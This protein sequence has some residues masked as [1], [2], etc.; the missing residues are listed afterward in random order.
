MGHANFQKILSFIAN[1]TSHLD[2]DSGRYRVG[3]I[4]YSDV[5]RTEFTLNTFNTSDQILEGIMRVKFRYGSANVAGAI[6]TLRET[7]QDGRNGNR[8]DVQVR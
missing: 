3:L 2:I 8:P 4:T 1:F 7:Y 5:E 6:R